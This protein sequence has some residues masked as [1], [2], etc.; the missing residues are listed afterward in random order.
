MRKLY[1]ICAFV[2]AL[3]AAPY[4]S[5][6]QS[7]LPE[8]FGSWEP[9]GQ[10]PIVMWPRSAKAASLDSHPEY[11]KLLVES[12]GF[13]IEERGYQKGGSELELRLFQLRDPSSSYEV[14]TSLISSEMHPSTVCEPSALGEGHL[15]LLI[16]NV[17]V[18]SWEPGTASTAD[19][20]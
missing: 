1:L 4:S 14:Y 15:L 18:E 6:Q 2:R 16:G 8:R 20:Q 5:A 12:G 13:R 3:A 10:P 11:T 7:L 19:V 9:D 17:V